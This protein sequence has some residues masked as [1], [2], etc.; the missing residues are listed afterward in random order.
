MIFQ[1]VIRMMARMKKFTPP[2]CQTLRNGLRVRW[3]IVVNPKRRRKPLR[4]VQVKYKSRM[5]T[6]TRSQRCSSW[7]SLKTQTKSKSTYET[8][9]PIRLLASWN[10]LRKESGSQKSPG[11]SL[12]PWWTKL[13]ERSTHWKRDH[14]PKR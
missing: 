2:L 14:Q 7:Q 3:T 12:N 10:Q 9:T 11:T 4:M 6:S 1:S 5:S 8:C 13:T